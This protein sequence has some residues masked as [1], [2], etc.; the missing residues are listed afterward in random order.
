MTEEHTLEFIFVC[1]CVPYIQRKIS[2]LKAGY[3]ETCMPITSN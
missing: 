2:G 1:T 3:S